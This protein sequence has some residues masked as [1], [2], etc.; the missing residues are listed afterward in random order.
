MSTQDE[1]D[2]DAV[3]TMV[4][5]VC[6]VDVPAGNFCGLCGAHRASAEAK[7]PRWLRGDAFGAAPNENVLLPSVASSLFPHIPKRSRAP[8]RV[9]LMLVLVG[10]VGFAIVKMPS[11]L[12]TIC[13]L[14]LPVLFLLYLAESGVYRDMSMSSLAAAGLLGAG[15]GVGWI[16]LTGE[17][18][19]RAYGVPMAAG[20]ALQ[21][22]VKEGIA[23]PTGGVLLMLVPTLVVRLLG[24]GS[25]ESLDG[26]VVGALSSL[27]FA[28]GAT[29]TRLAPQFATGLFAHG[30]PMKGLFVEAGICGVTIPL[31]AAVAGG[32]LGIALW[33][34]G[35]SG[36]AH[37][38]PGRIRAILFLL[39]AVVVL[40]HIGVACTDL[41]GLPQLQ[42]LGLHV[43]IMVIALILLR[44]SLQLALM[45][46]AHDPIQQDEPIL[47]IHCEMVVP[48]MAFC[49]AC[50]AAS[51]ASSRISRQ[52]RRESRPVRQVAAEGS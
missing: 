51:R 17:I 26:F 27:M 7:G 50:G 11:A 5:P 35:P 45:H 48:D 44:I 21:H 3:P 12:I 25:R 15:F 6:E 24:A 31:T 39:A 38:R 16:L 41:L 22:L 32:M 33:F 34:K 19:A 36:N 1:T 52:A 23:I 10:L 47:C 13:A 49:P 9:G 2:H 46:E 43:L 29:L 28:A 37:E 18:V 4:C 8:F 30:R 20:L 40:M 42:V 14:G